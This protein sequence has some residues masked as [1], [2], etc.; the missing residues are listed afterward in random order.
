MQL[1][2]GKS[3]EAAQEGPYVLQDNQ[4]LPNRPLVC[5]KASQACTRVSGSYVD[6]AHHF[7]TCTG[8]AALVLFSRMHC[9]HFVDDSGL[10]F[11][12]ESCCSDGW[13]AASC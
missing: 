5:A 4:V 8:F 1:Y 6:A 9:M 12:E 13:S 11:A 3:M 10:S 2:G 7:H